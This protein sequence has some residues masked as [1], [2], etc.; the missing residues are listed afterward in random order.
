MIQRLMAKMLNNENKNGASD[1]IRT[2]D[3]NVGNF[4]LYPWAT[5]AFIEIS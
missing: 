1:E 2:H 3:L 4:S 5:L